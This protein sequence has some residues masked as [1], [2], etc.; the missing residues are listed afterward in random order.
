MW[1]Q[2]LLNKT[3]AT[4]TNAFLSLNN[5]RSHNLEQYIFQLVREIFFQFKDHSLFS[6]RC[7]SLTLCLCYGIIW[8][9]RRVHLV[10]KKQMVSIW[11]NTLQRQQYPQLPEEVVK[12]K[13]Q[14]WK[15]WDEKERER[16]RAFCQDI[17]QHQQEVSLVIV[18]SE[19]YAQ[20]A[21]LTFLSRPSVA[22]VP[23]P[24]HTEQ[25][26][27][28]SGAGVHEHSEPAWADLSRSLFWLYFILPFK[29]MYIF[30]AY[31]FRHKTWELASGS[32]VK[33][34]SDWFI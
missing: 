1:L 12:A 26:K 34:V 18:T 28:S 5:L 10:L 3:R 21:G 2:E 23:H 33:V 8:L 14:D 15:T 7:W 31:T 32:D 4:V 29:W 16:R 24:D 17:L 20:T 13:G 11:F 30:A 27:D 25:S 9:Q 19:V 6:C 22:H